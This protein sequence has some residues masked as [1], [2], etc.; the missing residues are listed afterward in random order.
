M[1]FV[2]EPCSTRQHPCFFPQIMK[3]PDSKQLSLATASI[4]GQAPSELIKTIFMPPHKF[5]YLGIAF[6]FALFFHSLAFASQPLPGKLWQDLS[7]QEQL[8]LHEKERITMC[9]D[10]N[11]MPFEKIQHGQHLGMSADFMHLIQKQL[12]VPIQLVV[13]SSWQQ[14]VDY[15]KQRKCDIL[16]AVLITP[17]R[18]TFL[19]FTR[20]Y[21]DTPLVIVTSINEIF[22]DDIA[23][24]KDK[25]IAVVQGYAFYEMLHLKYPD[26]NLHE[27]ASI[28]EGMKQVEQGKYFGFLGSLA[29]VSYAFLNENHQTLKISGKFDERSQLGVGVRNDDRVLHLLLEK[30]V[31][32][33]TG[34]DKKKIYHNWI[35]VEYPKEIDYKLLWQ[36]FGGFVVIVLLLLYRYMVLVRYNQQLNLAQEKI[37]LQN[38]LLAKL[39]ITDKLTQLYNR[40]KLDEMLE[41]YQNLSLRY[42]EHFSI[43]LLDIDHFKKV[44]DNFGHPA[45]DKVLTSI[46]KILKSNIRANDIF[47]RW[48]GEEFMVICPVTDING[49]SNLAEQLRLKVAQQRLEKIGH[50]TISLGVA[51]YQQGETVKTLINR[52]DKALYSAKAQGRNSVQIE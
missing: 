8:Y 30:A 43:I 20:P 49:T 3:K 2:K 21:I 11:W 18:A 35:S 6:V 45:G 37:E 29:T 4:L 19:N 23:D 48:G 1:I 7:M 16:S 13:T 28:K 22:I 33:I 46:A 41:Y 15:A 36:L 10:P 32:A 39:A 26:F 34:S 40:A 24:I 52:V 5:A 38:Q 44:N 25:P 9:V 14:S 47:G 51:E 12:G 50:I 42:N 31:A 27:V 17:E